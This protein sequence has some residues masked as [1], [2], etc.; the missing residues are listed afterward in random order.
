MTRRL[1]NTD[2]HRALEELT[3]K[4]LAV[5]GRDNVAQVAV[6]QS[7]PDFGTLTLSA[8]TGIQE[9]VPTV[10][11]QTDTILVDG[12]QY[13]FHF[14]ED[15]DGPHEGPNRVSLYAADNI[16]GIDA[17]QVDDGI[18]AVREQLIGRPDESKGDQK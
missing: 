3:C 13:D 12:Q 2:T 8:H 15:L 11:E 14:V 18:E 6:N 17:V 5:R 10:V 9:A 1:D 4:Y 16:L 7:S